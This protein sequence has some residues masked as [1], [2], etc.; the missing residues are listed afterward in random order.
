MPVITPKAHTNSQSL[1][2]P[3]QPQPPPPPSK[4]PSAPPAAVPR[5]DG[6]ESAPAR[7]L[8]AL[9]PPIAA[10]KIEEVE[11]GSPLS[12]DGPIG[13]L[14]AISEKGPVGRNPWNSSEYISGSH[15]TNWRAYSEYLTLFGG[16]LSGL[17]PLGSMGPLTKEAWAALPEELRPGGSMAVTGPSGIL[18]ALGMLG[19]LGPVG[20]TGYKADADGNFRDTAGKV[21]RTVETPNGVEDLCEDYTE[22]GALKNKKLGSRYGVDA[23]IGAEADEFPI[24]SDR[25]HDELITLCATQKR[26]PSPGREGGTDILQLE[27]V[28][29]NGQVVAQRAVDG[30]PTWMQLRVPAGSDLKVRIKALNANSDDPAPY[31]LCVVGT[32]S[33][34]KEVN[35]GTALYA[36][37]EPKTP[38]RIA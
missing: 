17:G 32:G 5:E 14:S 28:D 7:P 25:K 2:G 33:H 18:G 10:M 12:I 4:P 30:G 34:S 16:P 27:V 8:V 35:G 3:A 13:Y 31:R 24:N 9:S 21:V 22:R 23:T 11:R 37:G 15:A 38:Q 36:P 19:V 26:F 6:F 20:A 29:K 1:R